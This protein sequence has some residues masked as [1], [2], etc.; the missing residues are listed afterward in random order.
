M[1][2]TSR[3]NRSAKNALLGQIKRCTLYLPFNSN[4]MHKK[5]SVEELHKI[6]EHVTKLLFEGNFKEVAE[7]YGYALSFDMPNDMAIKEEFEDSLNECIGDLS[8]ASISIN[9]KKFDKNDI[10]LS[11]LIECNVK[12]KK[13]SGI[14]VELIQSGEGSVYLEQISSYHLENHA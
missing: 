14:L 6:G 7:L 9:V 13:S 8:S 11:Y 2:I 4:V 12:L 10:E 5:M 1:N 3:L